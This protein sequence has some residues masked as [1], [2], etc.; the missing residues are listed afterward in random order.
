MANATNAPTGQ[1]HVGLCTRRIDRKRLEES[2]REPCHDIPAPF[3]RSIIASPRDDWRSPPM[4]G[5]A[6]EYAQTA[7]L[8]GYPGGLGSCIHR[9]E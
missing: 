1:W 8:V 5:S 9:E 6:E 7:R 4:A 2:A 3:A